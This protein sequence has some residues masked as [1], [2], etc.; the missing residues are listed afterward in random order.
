MGNELISGQTRQRVILANYLRRQSFW[1][2]KP[3]LT[4]EDAAEKIGLPKQPSAAL[5]WSLKGYGINFNSG[6]VYPDTLEEALNKRGGIPALLELRPM[7]GKITPEKAYLAVAGRITPWNAST[8]IVMSHP[9]PD[10]NVV[11]DVTYKFIASWI[12]G[13]GG[14]TPQQIAK[15]LMS[16]AAYFIDAPSLPRWFQNSQVFYR[17]VVAEMGLTAA[18][19][20]RVQDALLEFRV[21]GILGMSNMKIHG[22]NQTAGTEFNL[23]VSLY[24]MAETYDSNRPEEYQLAESPFIIA[25]PPA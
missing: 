24:Y 9:V 13:L 11:E 4:P 21:Q 12:K 23:G 15:I 16:T 6:C 20:S 7:D 17:R 1:R 18:E 14:I 5:V 8:K 2:I 19:R 10:L 22:I 3:E 25:S